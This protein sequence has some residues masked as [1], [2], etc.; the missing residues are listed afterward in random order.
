LLRGA[1]IVVALGAL[2]GA[3]ACTAVINS[4]PLSPRPDP[5][6]Q[7]YLSTGGTPRPF[8]TIGFAQVTGFGNEVA[9]VLSVGDA[10][11]DSTVRGALADAAVRMGGNGVIHIEFL[12]ENPRTP[13]EQAQD[14]GQS[15]QSAARGRG[16]VKTRWRSVHA[17]GEVIQFLQ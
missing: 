8:R 10:Q 7:I 14:L 17:T 13:A 16:E 11:L 12:D 2:V 6:N 9:G 1:R 4:A 5:S 3:A 15:L